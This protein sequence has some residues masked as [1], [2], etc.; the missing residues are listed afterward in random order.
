MKNTQKVTMRLSTKLYALIIFILLIVF[1]SNFVNSLNSFRDYLETESTTKSQDTST[2]LGMT[3]KNLISNKTDSE[4]TSTIRAIANRGFYKEVRLEDVQFNFKK[5][6]LLKLANIGEG[7]NIKDLII[8]K[9][10]GEITSTDLEKALE[11]ELAELEGLEEKNNTNKAETVY[12]FLPSTTFPKQSNLTIEFT[13]FNDSETKSVS[14]QIPINQILVQ[15]TRKEKFDEVPQFFIDLFPMKMSERKSL[16][17]DGWKTQ[18][19]IFVSANAGDAYL[20]LYE[21]AISAIIYTFALFTLSILLLAA[22]LKT[23]LKPLEKIEK[24]AIDI[25]QGNFNTIE[26]LPNTVELYNV[27]IAMNDMSEKIEN[28]IT[29]LNNNLHKMTEK[30]SKDDLTG[31]QKEQTFQTDMKQMFIKKEDGYIISVKIDNLA[32][33]AKNNANS[34]VDKFLKEFASILNTCDDKEIHAYRFFGS[35]FAL[36]SKKTQDEDINKVVEKLKISF[37]QLSQKYDIKNVANVG[38]TPFNPI[39]T[40]DAILASANEA[41]ELAKQIGSNEAFLKDKNDL[42]RDMQEWKELIFDIINNKKFNVGYINQSISTDGSRKLLMEEAFTSAQDKD[43]QNIPIGTFVSIA[44]QYNKVIDFD[45]AVIEEVINHIEENSINHKILINLAF[46]S[47]L[48]VPFSEWLKKLLT[49]HRNISHLLTFSVTAY[50]CTRDIEAFK[51][52]IRLL[53]R[54][55]ANVI[56]KRFETKFIPLNTLKE[57]NLD[58]IRLARDYTNG[59]SNDPSKQ[60]F[61]ESICEMSKLLNIKVFA[62]SVKDEDSFQALKDLGLIAASK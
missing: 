32:D 43:G 37:N 49:H 36:I 56:I 48:Y 22:F 53:H 42:A 20:K 9:N 46:D 54:N 27:T 31:L 14:V 52:F 25:A 23:I 39:S 62:E 33:F 18:A 4:I 2:L 59:I 21:H 10:D 50:G 38:V 12:S 5:N 51:K 19:I 45:K 41:Y 13:A 6:D 34:L 7:Y 35:T 40:T 17:S 57:F 24:L 55:G 44:E 60:N 47:I 26:E 1:A 15:V 16:I 29:K 28:I 30:I 8:N 58:Y 3:L 11:A 61:V